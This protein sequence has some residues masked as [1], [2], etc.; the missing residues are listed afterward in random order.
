[1]KIAYKKEYQDTDIPFSS[2]PNFRRSQIIMENISDD[3]FTNES[4]DIYYSYKNNNE[5]YLITAGQ[6][7][8][9]KITQLK[10]KKLI[11]ILTGH[12]SPVIYLKHFFNKKTDKDYLLSIDK[13]FSLT[14]IWDLSNY[15]I[16]QK[17]E[18]V[19][20]KI[21]NALLIFDYNSKND[22]I[23][24]SNT[25]EKNSPPEERISIYSVET[26]IF[27]RDIINHNLK[28]NFMLSWFNEDNNNN[29]IIAFCLGKIVIYDLLSS[30]IYTE[31]KGYTQFEP[32]CN[33][34]TGCLIGKEKLFA[35][36]EEGII[37]EWD[38]IKQRLINS[39][40]VKNC[41]LINNILKWSERYIIITEKFKYELCVIDLV[42]KKIINR[43]KIFKKSILKIKKVKIP[44]YGEC[45]VTGD[46]DHLIK[47]WNTE[48]M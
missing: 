16:R 30:E 26:G 21:K 18:L 28:S 48:K 37:N 19:N 27:Q 20:T 40:E 15:N 24:L 8:D 39:F 6:D 34:C 17:I 41:C 47:I 2:N 14:N 23:I 42:Y 35:F 11:K 29:Y 38:L 7:N 44:N 12:L 36:C 43:M 10:D 22:Y 25:I 31:L 46:H 13:T 4:F 45:L 3:Y 1:M 32:D 5:P 33:Y 9:I